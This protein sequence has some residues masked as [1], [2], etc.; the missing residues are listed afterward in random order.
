M[1]IEILVGNS[2][3]PLIYPLNKPKIV[4]GSA[5]TCDVIIDAS[6]V[7]RKHLIILSEGESYYVIDQGSTNGSFINEE[8]LVPGRRTEFTSFFPV[9][10]GDSIL[11]TLLSDEEQTEE[12]IPPLNLNEPPATPKGRGTDEST[13]MISLG[14]FQKAK[15]ADLVKRRETIVKKKAPEK[16]SKPAIKSKRVKEKKHWRKI[17]FMVLVMI[18]VA[19]YINFYH[20]ERG[21]EEVAQIGEEIPLNKPVEKK[22]EPPK[23]EYLISENEIMSKERLQNLLSDIKCTLEMEKY[24]CDRIYKANE[25][26]FGVVR[27]GNMMNVLL[28]GEVFYQEAAKLLPFPA[29]QSPDG[30]HTPEEIAT[31][32]NYLREVIAAIFV[33]RAIPADIDYEMIKDLKMTYALFRMDDD[34]VFRVHTAIAILPE[35]IKE[36][37]RVFEEHQLQTISKIGMPAVNFAKEI[38]R[39]Y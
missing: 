33:L 23:P 36:F 2:E 9:R 11:I 16:E 24:F 27:V 28:D 19:A 13:K 12:E 7:S 10:L 38:Y 26:Q 20:L 35:G 17:Q 39:V 25:G 31:H 21:P 22:E 30:V 1:R 6:K 18:G 4:L 15:T 8:R 3:E 37:K 34:G 32:E 29:S 5:E 14:D